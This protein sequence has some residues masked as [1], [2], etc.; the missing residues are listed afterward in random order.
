MKKC[1]TLIVFLAIIAVLSSCATTKRGMLK[2]NVYYSTDSPNVQITVDPRFKY[3]E[4]D[5]GELKHQFFDE[6]NGR[7]FLIHHI[8]HPPNESQV[9]YYEHP[10]HWIFGDIPENNRIDTG[11]ITLLNSKWYYCNSAA[12][13]GGK[14]ILARD[15]RRFTG[16]NDMFFIKYFELLPSSDC[17]HWENITEISDRQRKRID[18]LVG[19]FSKFAEITGYIKE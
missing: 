9:D 3:A 1:R 12:L 16:N 15:I 8:K 13:D 5:T 18:L 17:E 10:V 6:N 7:G 2:E 14:C 19:N 4:G 11:E